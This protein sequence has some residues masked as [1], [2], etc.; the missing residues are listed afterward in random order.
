M[1]LTAILSS[2]GL[3]ALSSTPLAAHP[4]HHGDALSSAPGWIHYVTQPDHAVMVLVGLGAVV[5][6]VGLVDALRARRVR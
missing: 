3:L 5:V 6:T 4:G 1:K 2:T